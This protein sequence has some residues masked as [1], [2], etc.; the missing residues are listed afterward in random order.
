MRQARELGDV[1]GLARKRGTHA[2]E[3][4]GQF[5]TL[6]NIG[7]DRQNNVYV[8][9]RNNRRIQVFDPNGKFQRMIHLNVLYDKSG[10]RCS[11]I[12]R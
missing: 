8:A 9:D 6:H 10:T 3:N 4:P 5:N 12:S 11:A 7:N 2:D 1:V